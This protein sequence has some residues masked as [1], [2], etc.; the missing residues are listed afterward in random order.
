VSHIKVLH[1][2]A[3]FLDHRIECV[4]DGKTHDELLFLDAGK[5]KLI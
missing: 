1:T 3:V 2:P 5:A 4:V